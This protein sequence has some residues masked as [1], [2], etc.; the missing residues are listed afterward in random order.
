MNEGPWRIR[1]TNLPARPFRSVGR[2]FRILSLKI[3]PQHLPAHEIDMFKLCIQKNQFGGVHEI[4]ISSYFFHI[5]ALGKKQANNI[6]TRKIKSL[7]YN[8]LISKLKN[9]K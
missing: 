9:T 3:R 5:S 1:T 6:Y 8:Y 7:R 4:N 2:S